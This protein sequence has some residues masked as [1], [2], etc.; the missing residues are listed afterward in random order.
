M[1]DN[2]L[3]IKEVVSNT[4]GDFFADDIGDVVYAPSIYDMSIIMKSAD[5]KHNKGYV[6]Q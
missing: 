1:K 6:M 2:E 5:F 3:S 4:I